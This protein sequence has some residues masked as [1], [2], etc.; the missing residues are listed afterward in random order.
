[1]LFGGV[2]FEER[3]LRQLVGV[4]PPT[5][6]RRL[7]TALFHRAAVLG[8]T[9]PERRA[10]FAALVNPPAGLE[11]LGATSSDSGVPPTARDVL[12]ATVQQLE[13]VPRVHAG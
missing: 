2:P 3:L 6:A 7:E 1:M 5:V 4:V 9:A 11:N 12:P 13:R 10:I 8:L